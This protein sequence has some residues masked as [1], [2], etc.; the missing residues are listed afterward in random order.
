[1]LERDLHASSDSPRRRAPRSSALALLGLAL[2]L[3][4]AAAALAGSAHAI[5]DA[6]DRDPAVAQAEAEYWAAE[7]PWHPKLVHVPI[8]LCMLMP[9][10]T[11]GILLLVRLGWVDRRSFIIAAG[12]QV[13]LAASSLAALKSGHDDAVVVEGYASDQAMAAHDARA[14]QFVYVAV[15]TSLLFGLLLLSDRKRAL[16]PLALAVVVVAVMVQGYAGYRVGDA[17]GRLVYVGTAADAH[18]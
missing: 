16:Q 15:G 17:G 9:A 2:V 7:L 13:A 8:A 5:A 6:P 18:R 11:L 3:V 10:L 12:L 14:H 4:L 1:M